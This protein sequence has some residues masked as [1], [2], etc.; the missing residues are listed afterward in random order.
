MRVCYTDE[1]V[2]EVPVLGKVLV[3]RFLENAVE[4]DVDALC[5]GTDAYIAAVMEFLRSSRFSVMVITPPDM[6][7]M[8]AP[9][10]KTLSPL[11]ACR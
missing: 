2:F 11:P 10:L 1:E 4:I 9:P 6:V 3:D 5:D 7:S 8:P